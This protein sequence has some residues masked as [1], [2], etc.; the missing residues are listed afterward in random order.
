MN[1]LP[2]DD[3]SDQDFN[4]LLNDPTPNLTHRLPADLLAKLP[5]IADHIQQARHDCVIRFIEV[6]LAHPTPL[7]PIDLQRLALRHKADFAREHPRDFEPKF[8]LISSTEIQLTKLDHALADQNSPLALAIRALRVTLR[9]LIDQ[10]YLDLI[11][12]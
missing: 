11:L 4:P 2:F 7:T 12:I 8:E 10:E 9:Q 6:L 3:S 5:L 1:D